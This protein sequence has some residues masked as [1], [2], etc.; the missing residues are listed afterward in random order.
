MFDLFTYLIEGSS[1][2]YFHF[3]VRGNQSHD[4]IFCND[5]YGWISVYVGKA[6]C[7]TYFI[8]SATDVPIVCVEQSE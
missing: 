4:R 8:F 7:Q 2:K 5:E 3:P 1:R 6:N